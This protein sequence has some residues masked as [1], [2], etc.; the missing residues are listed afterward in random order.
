MTTSGGGFSSLPFLPETPWSPCQTIEGLCEL[1]LHP[2]RILDSPRALLPKL[3][4]YKDTP[5]TLQ[6][7]IELS[8]RMIST[9]RIIS[10]TAK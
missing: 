7:H 6:S 5:V 2:S 1:T 4:R 10:N 3:N 9:K 8:T